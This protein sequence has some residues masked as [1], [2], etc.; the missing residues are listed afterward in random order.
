MDKLITAYKQTKK[1]RMSFN[2]FI[3]I[4]IPSIYDKTLCPEGYHIMNCFMQYTPYHPNNGDD[5]SPIPHS[6]VK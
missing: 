4:T 5:P 3:D 6:L 2:P 1:S